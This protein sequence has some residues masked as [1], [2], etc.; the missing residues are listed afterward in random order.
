[1]KAYWR[2]RARATSASFGSAKLAGLHEQNGTAMD[3]DAFWRALRSR[4]PH[5]RVALAQDACVT[6]LHRGERYEF[7]SPLDTGLQ[8]LRLAWVSDAFLAQALYRM[9]ARLQ[10]LGVP[11]LPRIAHRLAMVLAQIS[12]GDP[13]VIQPGVY[14][15]HGQFVADGLVEIESG[16]V[17]APFVTIGLRA[18]DVQG[19]TI[20]QNVSIGT[21][22]KVIGPVRI[23]AGA[24]IGANA[25]VVDDVPA[26][27]SVVGAPARPVTRS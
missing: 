5:L 1:M 21:G 3:K 4:H 26:G 17:I 27:E 10:A 20:G 8:V 13:V 18:G 9:K 11:V 6:A 12:I 19:A 22:A 25:V 24:R 14:I 16:V 7:R 23:G 2:S 15:I